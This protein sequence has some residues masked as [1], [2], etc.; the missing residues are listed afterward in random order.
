MTDVSHTFN[1]IF[2]IIPLWNLQARWE[3][4][5]TLSTTDKG[6]EMKSFAVDIFTFKAEL[7]GDPN[8]SYELNLLSVIPWVT[9]Q[10]VPEST[11]TQVNS[12]PILVN[13]Y[14]S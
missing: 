2:E 10:L 12:V 4:L 6:F 13:S 14:P 3:T 1:G 9:G 5:K 8:L 11:R 7:T